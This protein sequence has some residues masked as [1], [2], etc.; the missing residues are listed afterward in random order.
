MRNDLATARVPG[1][2]VADLQAGCADVAL[3]LHSYIR[4]ICM[5]TQIHSSA[6]NQS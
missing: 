5:R 3:Q 4:S 1:L 6:D 2:I